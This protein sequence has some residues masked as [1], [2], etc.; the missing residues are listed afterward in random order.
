MDFYMA[1]IEPR[2]T[3]SRTS[4]N[5]ALAQRYGSFHKMC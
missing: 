4:A 2:Y 5:Q 3:N 1:V